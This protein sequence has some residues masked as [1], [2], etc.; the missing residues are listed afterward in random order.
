[1]G[2]FTTDPRVAAITATLT[3]TK[4]DALSK[5]GAHDSVSSLNSKPWQPLWAS[6]SLAGPYQQYSLGYGGRGSGQHDTQQTPV[7]STS[8]DQLLTQGFHPQDQQ[9]TQAPSRQHR[10]ITTMLS[11]LCCPR[12]S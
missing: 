9:Y 12:K 4:S 1:M 8:Y 2:N 3:I 11:R 10:H 7:T 6:A 5:P